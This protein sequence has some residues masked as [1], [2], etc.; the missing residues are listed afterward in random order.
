MKKIAIIVGLCLCTVAGFAQVEHKVSHYPNGNLR[1][2]G[3]F[4]DGKPV[5]ELRR[6]HENGKLSGIQTFDNEGNSKVVCYAGSG[7]LLAEG[8]YKGQK[9]DGLWQFYGAGE[10][11]FMIETYKDGLRIGES[12]IFSKEGKVLQRMNYKDGKLDGERIQYYPYGNVM[13]KYTYKDG[14]LEGPYSYFY[15]TGQKN[16]EGAY[17]NGKPHGIWR[18]Y[19]EDGSVEET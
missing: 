11:L 15:E 3:D 12:L 18:S 16:E 8:N 10:Y 4:K 17:Q 2:E 1:Y 19:A 9:R 6:Y 13:A 14:V 7:E 5:G